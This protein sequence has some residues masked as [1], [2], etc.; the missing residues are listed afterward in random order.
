MGDAGAS[1]L[2]GLGMAGKKIINIECK[3][4]IDHERSGSR[5]KKLSK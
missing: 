1:I 2:F 5:N 4:F 3:E